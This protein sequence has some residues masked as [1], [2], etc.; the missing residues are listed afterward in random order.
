MW[1]DVMSRMSLSSPDTLY[2]FSL[3]ILVHRRSAIGRWQLVSSLS[4]HNVI[5]QRMI[6]G[7]E[8]YVSGNES[9]TERIPERGAESRAITKKSKSRAGGVKFPCQLTVTDSVLVWKNEK[10]MSV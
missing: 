9:Q 7:S 6:T 2:G 10:Q 4:A 8:G 3:E 5:I 1:M